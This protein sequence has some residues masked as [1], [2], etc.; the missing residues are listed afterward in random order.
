MKLVSITLHQVS[1]P[2]VTPFETSFMRE[3]E[4]DCYLVEAT[5][6]TDRGE[7]T[8]WGESV[9]MI[10]PLYSSEYVAAGID[11][12]R[13]WLAPILFDVD[14]LT[15]ETVGWHL[16]HVVGHPMAKSALEM[17][18]IDAQLQ[19]NG[20]SFKSYL[21]GVVDS[22]PSGVSVGIQ[23]TVEETVR[24]IGD[25]LEEGYA[26]IKLKIKPG[27]DIAPVA[28][29]REAFGDDFGFQV[30][31]NAAYTLVDASHLRRLDDYGL[32]L[33]EQ[34]LGEADIR[35]HAELAK[36]METP[37]CL[38]ESI[39]SAE[40]AADAI[41][42]GAAAVINIKPGRVGGYIEAKR[43][44]D[45][46]AANGVAVWH[47][48]MVE[49]GLGRAANAALASLPGF[50]LPGDISGSNRFF[51]EDIT[52]EIVMKD[53]RVDVPDTVGFGVTIDPA[54]L[55]KFRTESIDIRPEG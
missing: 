27:K 47:G 32:L 51:H 41:A 3:T 18:V 37:M 29:V 13:R 36:L 53:G 23:D 28:A 10:S 35:Q 19:L 20:Q 40:A 49:T 17:A 6:D 16:R 24:V 15:A 38:D 5:F 42:L 14:D 12:T 22:V 50:T 31:A 46:S 52:E 54:K 30:D 1:I 43:I 55:E 34:P 45:L 7:I 2:L 4:K 48:G 39:V 9:A 11:V 25:Y 44:H 21:G 33:I 8:G 26:R